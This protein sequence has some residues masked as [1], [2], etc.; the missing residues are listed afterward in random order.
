MQVFGLQTELGT[1]LML[2]EDDFG[3]VFGAVF[4]AALVDSVGQP[5]DELRRQFESGELGELAQHWEGL[6]EELSKRYP[7]FSHKA[8]R[9]CCALNCLI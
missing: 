2:S 5:N 6:L 8:V 3:V 9:M 1:S 7:H 4:G